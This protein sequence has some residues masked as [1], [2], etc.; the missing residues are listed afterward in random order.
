M[1]VTP[2]LQ[3]NDRWAFSMMVFKSSVEMV[4]VMLHLECEVETRS[5][6]E[7]RIL[8]VRDSTH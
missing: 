3:R 5:K 1:V 8:Q 7:G 2:E 6:A 4:K